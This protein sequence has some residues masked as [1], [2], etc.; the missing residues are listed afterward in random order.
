[1]LEVGPWRI[2]SVVNGHIRLDGGAMF[3]VVPRVLWERVAPP[4]DLNRILLATRTL[5]AVHQPS[6][7]IVLVD[8]GTGGKWP[9]AQAERYGVES[10]PSAIGDA[11]A[12]IGASPGDVTD[13]IATHLHFDHCGGMTEWAE[14]PYGETRLR[15]GNAR[16]WVSARHWAHA[17]KPTLR[18]RASFLPVDFATLAGSERHKLVA[19]GAASTIDDLSWQVSNGHTPGQLL[20]RFLGSEDR[21]LLFIGDLAPTTAHLPPAWVMAY[22]LEPLTTLGERLAVYEQLRDRDMLIAFPHDPKVG[23]V[24]L[25]LDEKNRPQ[26][27]E[28]VG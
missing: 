21:D 24:A 19:E 22:D 17:Q 10:T 9:A 23:I 5:L 25:T 13:V 6:G 1:M 27:A 7:R 3:G 15:F 11:L 18:D 8:T 14:E 12:R 4:D 20:P 26:V 28:V 2:E 16:H